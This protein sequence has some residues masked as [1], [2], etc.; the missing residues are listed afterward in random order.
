M[1]DTQEKPLKRDFKELVKK[2]S[3]TSPQEIVN[4]RAHLT[5]LAE[6]IKHPFFKLLLDNNYL[7]VEGH[8][9]Q[10][11]NPALFSLFCPGL[12]TKTEK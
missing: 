2:K 10:D 5:S 12:C 3:S 11:F 1:D 6:F 7:S 4:L 8:T 9:Y